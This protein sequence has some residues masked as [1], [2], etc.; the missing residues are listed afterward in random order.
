MLETEKT[1]TPKV[2]PG[3]AGWTGSERF[4]NWGGS[5]DRIK[6]FSG[7]DSHDRNLQRCTPC[8]YRFRR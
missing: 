3:A 2:R 5:L 4:A 7:A 6:G 1:A 8:G